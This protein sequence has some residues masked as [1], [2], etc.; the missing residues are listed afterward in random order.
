MASWTQ[1]GRVWSSSSRWWRT[2]KPGRLRSWGCKQLDTTEQL[3]NNKFIG[4]LMLSWISNTVATWCKEQT[5]WKTLMLGKI[6]DRRRSRWQK[7]RWLNGITYSMDMNLSKFW[8]IV[9]ETWCFAVHGVTK[10]Q[11]WLSMHANFLIA[12][13]S[14]HYRTSFA[15]CFDLKY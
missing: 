8:E 3:N 13:A 15:H 14:V 10:S 1:W 4:R 11:T 12:A 6:E 7:M 2:E 5:N 9:K